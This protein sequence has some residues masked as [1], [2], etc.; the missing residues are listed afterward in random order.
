MLL[1][2]PAQQALIE[3]SE[4]IIVQSDLS[5]SNPCQYCGLKYQ[6]KSAHLRSCIGIFSGVA[7]GRPLKDLAIGCEDGARGRSKPDVASNQGTGAAEV[8]CPPDCA[9]G[10]TAPKLSLNDAAIL[11]KPG[12]L[13]SGAAVQV[14]QG[15]PQ[16][17][18]RQRKGRHREE[19]SGDIRQLLAGVQTPGKGKNKGAKKWG[20]WNPWSE[21]ARSRTTQRRSR[22]SSRC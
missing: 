10:P 11:T 5:L 3:R 17:K 19:A 6:R 22:R 1:K 8:V 20:Q 7:R 14:P 12:I 15:K 18:R 4:Q 13:G 9:P 2:H 21:E 16:Q